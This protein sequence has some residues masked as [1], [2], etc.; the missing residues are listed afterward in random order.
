MQLVYDY[1]EALIDSG[2]HAAAV[3]FLEGQLQR[4]PND[5]KLH[6]LAAKSYAA[7][8]KKLQQHAH[9]GEFYVRLGNLRGAIEQFELATKATDGNF[10][11]ISTAESRLRAVK[12]EL[13]DQGKEIGK[14]AS[15]NL[16]R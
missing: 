1:P 16:Q 7:L 6:Q 10:Y 12:Q 13:A 15:Q 9:Q 4:F 11:Q 3:Q 14:L 5:G 2:Q 8:G